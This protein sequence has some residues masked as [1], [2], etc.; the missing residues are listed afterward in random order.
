VSACGQLCRSHSQGR[1]AGR[2][3]G[4]GADQVRASHQPQD[5]ER[6]RTQNPADAARARRR[7]D[8]MIAAMNRRQF[9]M[10]LGGAVAA[11]PLAP[12]A[13]QPAMPVVGFVNGGSPDARR[14]AAFRKGLNGAGYV[15]GQKVTVEYHW[16]EGQYDHL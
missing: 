9:I 3:A 13:Q 4:A 1:E 7:G 14:A 5:S 16:L 10:L 8:R 11:W 12:R 2:P 6:A 15:E